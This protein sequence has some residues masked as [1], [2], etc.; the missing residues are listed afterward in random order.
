MHPAIDC[1]YMSRAETGGIWLKEKKKTSRLLARRTKRRPSWAIGKAFGLTLGESKKGC[2]LESSASP[3]GSSD[4]I[5][6]CTYRTEWT[7]WAG[8]DSGRVAGWSV[9]GVVVYW[10]GGKNAAK[11]EKEGKTSTVWTLRGK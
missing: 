4:R 9:F 5:V 2:K 8:L 1:Q 10:E 11:Y 3:L 6:R 7:D